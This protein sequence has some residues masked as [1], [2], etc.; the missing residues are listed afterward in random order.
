ML[1]RYQFFI[2]EVLLAIISCSGNNKD[3]PGNKDPKKA[4]SVETM[5]LNL[6]AL[7]HTYTFTG[8]LLA[9]EE[10][11]LRSETSG[12]VVQINF[13]EGRM[14]RK[15]Q[16]LVKINDND[17]QAQLK[18]NML[19]LEL[20]I[21]DESRKSELL[22]I[23]GISKEEYDN[24]LI[25]LKSLQAETEL[26]SA[27]I[28]KTEIRAPFDGTIGLRMVSEGAYVSPTTLIASL[29]QID[30]IKIDFSVPEK[31][32]QYIITNKEIDFTIEGSDKIYKA[33]I[34]AVEAKIDQ[35]TRTIRIRASCSNHNGLL[36]PGS[37]ANIRI[38]LIPGSKS[39]VIP[40]RAIIPILGGQQV[41]IIKNGMVF[42][43]RVKTGI[44]TSTEVEIIEG[45]FENDSLIMS[46][47]LQVKPGM[48]VNGIVINGINKQ[49]GDLD[50]ANGQD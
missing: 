29:Q 24:S 7:D 19:Q 43:V 2:F 40:A 11:E 14:V 41:F 5:V 38:N 42:P 45:L 1:R 4:M 46:G 10:I 37:Y 26:I 39:I 16:L 49:E 21:L 13:A 17:L 33:R 50:S 23:N 3:L 8:T 12:R 31:Y 25:K 9:N 30:P 6:K 35:A 36:Y 32:K 22:K 18:K 28:A 34:Y 48:P 27:Q 44:R 15:G 20:A 47:L